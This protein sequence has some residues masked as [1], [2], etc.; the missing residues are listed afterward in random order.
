MDANPDTPAD[1]FG[2]KVVYEIPPFQRPYVWTRDEQWEPLWDDIA[3]LADRVVALDGAASAVTP[4]FLGAVVLKQLP[5]AAGEPNRYAVIDGQQ[6]MTT[7]Q[8]LIDALQVV[9]DDVGDD[10]SAELLQELVAN[11]SMR[12]RGTQKRFKLWPSRVDRA[13]FESVMDNSM[14]PLEGTSIADA[15]QFFRASAMEWVGTTADRTARIAALAAAV[16]RHL[17]IVSISLDEQDDDQL[18]FETLND[19][20]TPLLAS[21]LIKNFVFLR[22]E[23]LRADVD[24]WNSEY[25]DDFDDLWWRREVSQGR[26][27]RSRIDMFVQYWLTMR[28]QREVPSD[29][30]FRR[31]REET[32][33]SFGQHD[34]AEQLLKELRHD[35]DL[36]RELVDGASSGAA[37]AFYSRVVEGLEVGTMIP[38]LLWL[39]SRNNGVSEGQISG[40]LDSLESWVVRRTLTRRNMKDVNNFVLSLLRALAEA[41]PEEVAIVT[42][43]FLADQTAEARLWP[44][45]ED[46]RHSLENWGVYGYIRQGRIR[47]ILEVIESRTRTGRTE[48]L[49]LPENLEVEHIMPKGWREHW[50]GVADEDAAWSRDRLIHT[51]GNLT[52]ITKKLNGSLSNRPWTDAD[53]HDITD[54]GERGLGKRSLID[55]YSVLLLNKEVTIGHESEWTE[56]DIRRRSRA[57]AVRV[58]EIWPR[59]ES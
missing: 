6:R 49:G 27:Y 19:R 44:T 58:S 56:E 20:G 32:A 35:A 51:I 59:P 1:L 38:V 39:A 33:A 24:R 3:R 45:D 8:I 17:V 10:E 26:L 25:W 22:G 41:A 46:L 52:L 21:D 34:S 14:T 5:S 47:L 9:A 2:G 37:S 15:H 13:A 23:D 11:G 50:Q 57:L 36:Y 31:F 30:I 48:A 28:S 16:E 43:A 53:A 55:K 18:I 42:A 40:A 29:E 54:G 12:F 7:L 4:H